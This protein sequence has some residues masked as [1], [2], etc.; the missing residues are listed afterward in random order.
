MSPAGTTPSTAAAEASAPGKPAVSTER[1]AAWRERADAADWA[2]IRADLDAHGCALAGPLLT[3]DEA[4]EIAALYTHDSRFRSTISMGRYRFGEGEYRY[5]SEPFP[6][7]VIGLK[8]ALY[9]KLLP[10]ARE[11][12]TRL[13]PASAVAGQ[14]A[15]VAGHV[16]RC[17]ADEVHADPAQVRRR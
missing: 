8:Q 16:P 15:A 1:A 12:W 5:F 10:I 7:A 14:P 9:P 6:D 3:P 17:R 2:A 4:G 13:G 11:W